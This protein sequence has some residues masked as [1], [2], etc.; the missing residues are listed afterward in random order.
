MTKYDIIFLGSGPGGYVGAIRAAQLGKKV[1]VVEK[2]KLG[3]VCL[4]IGCIP[5][6]A[7]LHSSSLLYSFKSAK[8]FG[9]SIDGEV[10]FDFSK[11]IGRSRRVS[12]K[13][14]KG[15]EFLFKKNGV[16]VEKGFGKI[17]APHKVEVDNGTEKK[18]FEAD[19]II[20]ATGARPK[21][22]PGISI[23][24]ERVISYRKALTLEKLPESM[25]IIGSG[26]IGTEMA[27][28]YSSLGTKITLV[29]FLPN[30]VPLED[31]EISNELLNI[32]KKRR[33]E[34]LVSSKVVGVDTSGDLCKV[35]IETPEGIVEKEVEIVLSAAGVTA[36]IENIGL[37]E[38]G[39][40]VEKG[41]IKTDEFYRTNVEGIYAIGDVINTPALAHVASAE[42]ITCVEKIARLAVS[43]ID[44][45]SI[46]SC[47]Y[48]EPEISSVGLTEKHAKE[49]G[50]NVKIGKFPFSALGKA[51]AS[52]H[53]EGFVKLVFDAETDT[54]VGAHII[55]EG[56]TN[57]ISE[58]VLAKKLKAKAADIIKSIHPHPTMSEAI[59]EAAAQAEG[60]A[61]HI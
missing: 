35:K 24:E 23:D 11:I 14:S 15:I 28:F 54:I 27:F 2:D 31:E 18:L 61:I 38:L 32:L 40:T 1:L 7:L 21:Q 5:T 19:H 37:E 16:E 33:I 52:G 46:P 8:Q 26:A 36:N 53:L 50:L 43:P 25:L 13:M 29:E 45:S 30:V 42:G 58:L 4:N 55:G 44:Y 17:V 41:K 57:M 60:E 48:S 39:V 49:S 12:A 20:I 22:L 56:A 34:T 51:S 3:G 9:I 47:V 59:M 6:K 10:N